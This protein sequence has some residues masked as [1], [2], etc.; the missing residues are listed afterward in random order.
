MNMEDSEDPWQS[1]YHLAGKNP[2]EMDLDPCP[3]Y[4]FLRDLDDRYEQEQ[5]L[6]KGGMKKITKAFDL[7][8]SRTV[9][10]ARPLEDLPKETYDAFIREAQLTSHLDHPNIIKVFDLGVD[11][12]GCPFFT[13]ELKVGDDLKE[14]ITKQKLSEADDETFEQCLRDNLEIF[15]KVCD[16]IAYAHSVNV[17]HL[18]LK[19]SN[20]QVGAFGEVL[21]CDWGLGKL[22]GDFGEFE[23]AESTFRPEMINEV[24]HYGEIRGTP[25]YMAPEQVQPNLKKDTLTDIYALGGILYYI[26]CQSNPIKGSL[27]EIIDRTKSNKITWPIERNP[28]LPIPQS[29][30]AVV[31][32]AMALNPEDRYLNVESLRKEVYQYLRGFATQAEEAS[33]RRQLSLLYQRNKGTFLAIASVFCVFMAL[34]MAS[35]FI[36]NNKNKALEKSI[37]EKDENL[38]KYI[39]EK[40]AKEK[41]NESFNREIENFGEFFTHDLIYFLDTNNSLNRGEM[42]MKQYAKEN[43]KSE[44]VW[45]NLGYIHFLK[46]EFNEAQKCF[47]KV[48]HLEDSFTLL[49][50]VDK[51]RKIK[52]KDEELLKA[53]ELVELT[54]E[55]HPHHRKWLLIRMLAYDHL[56]RKDFFGYSSVIKA[57]LQ[58]YNPLTADVQSVEYQPRE[59]VLSVRGNIQVWGLENDDYRLCLFQIFPIDHLD[60]R[61]SGLKDLKYISTLKIRSLDIRQNKIS[62]LSAL[63]D[64]THLRILKIQ[65]GQFTKKQLL[66]VPA[67]I[68]IEQLEQE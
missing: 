36:V 50:V 6:A 14:H 30:D 39:Q 60:L 45:L 37:R 11:E 59:G 26:L 17:I 63:A 53:P 23:S 51:Y 49:H 56:N 52:R 40:Q 29:L 25:G 10:I 66:Q 64:M 4:H 28:D 15:L 34:I 68:K 65:I 67:R 3:A 16:A 5:E 43:P 18:D 58:F 42:K 2:Q 41:I 32:K 27:T 8:N 31:R 62:D 7:K 35:T 20:I 1:F 47:S 54:K 61:S 38:E 13:M 22:I 21:V 55:F 48:A 12:N 44:A 24:T 9:A 19:P 33:F 46:Q 57:Y